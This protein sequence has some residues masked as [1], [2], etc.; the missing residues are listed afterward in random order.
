MTPSATRRFIDLIG[1]ARLERGA[2]K[3][4]PMLA[5]SR[6]S[7]PFLSGKEAV[8]LSLLHPRYVVFNPYLPGSDHGH[9]YRSGAGIERAD[10]A[11]VVRIARQ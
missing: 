3:S 1:E 9:A 4:E 6:V 10:L 2:W 8:I 5:N 11:D 7:D